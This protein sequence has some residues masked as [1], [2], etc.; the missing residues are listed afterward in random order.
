MKASKAR[1]QRFTEGPPPTQVVVVPLPCFSLEPAIPF[2]LPPPVVPRNLVASDRQLYLQL[3]RFFNNTPGTI[4]GPAG[5]ITWL[6]L[7][8]WF[9]ISSGYQVDPRFTPKMRRA[10]NV[11][12]NLLTKPGI[13]TILAKFKQVVRILMKVFSPAHLKAFSSDSGGSKR[14]WAVGHAHRS[15]AVAWLPS[16]SLQKDANLTSALLHMKRGKTPHQTRSCKA[17]PKPT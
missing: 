7:L 10:A 17:L 9:E 5:G 11:P 1:V 15:P 2:A 3:H 6:E 16:S 12:A 13:L 8:V 14:L 4:T